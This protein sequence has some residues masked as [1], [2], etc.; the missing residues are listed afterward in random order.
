MSPASFHCGLIT[1]GFFWAF[2]E[3][4]WVPKNYNQVPKT[5]NPNLGFTMKFLGVLGCRCVAI[6][7]FWGLR[8]G[9]IDHE[10]LSLFLAL[11]DRFPTKKS[12]ASNGGGRCP[13]PHFFFW[14]SNQRSSTARAMSLSAA[15]S[16]FLPLNNEILIHTKG[17]TRGKC[18]AKCGLVSE[19]K[20]RL[21]DLGFKVLDF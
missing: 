15:A 20:W 16:I 1:E 19:L 6:E 2:E 21:G 9:Y 11:S 3:L 14:D 5:V 13:G 4:I 18:D 10:R 12:H 17:L 8:V 7:K